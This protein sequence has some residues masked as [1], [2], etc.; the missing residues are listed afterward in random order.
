MP[1]KKISEL[2]W[3]HPRRKAQRKREYDRDEAR[4]TRSRK[5]SIKR[6]INKFDIAD[7]TGVVSSIERKPVAKN[8]IRKIARVTIDVGGK[9]KGMFN[10][11]TNYDWEE[12]WGGKLTLE[13]PEEIESKFKLA[14]EFS[15][16][17]VENKGKK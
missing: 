16:S 15:L 12:H 14:Q 8:S 5:A 7:N 17:L 2:P 1:R 10:L 4:R 6:Y 13:V 9:L 11:S 3:D